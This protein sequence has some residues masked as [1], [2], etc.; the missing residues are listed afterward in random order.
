[1][2][3]NKAIELTINILL[4]IVAILIV[5]WFIHFVAVKYVA[6]QPEISRAI[7]A[8]QNFILGV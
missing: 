6:N 7:L 8:M 2:T 1:M 3:L 5:C 4:A